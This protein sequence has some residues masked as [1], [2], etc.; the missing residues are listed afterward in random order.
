[1]FCW[2]AHAMVWGCQTTISGAELLLLCSYIYRSIFP[3][4]YKFNDIF[5][6]QFLYRSFFFF[7]QDVEDKMLFMQFKMHDLM[8]DL[9]LSSAR[10]ECS[11]ISS[12]NLQ[13]SK[14]TWHLTFLDP[15]FFFPSSSYTPRD[16]IVQEHFSFK[17]F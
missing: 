2:I 4:D 7:F 11:I 13:I 17:I 6:V 16:W 14:T 15:H 8:H 5:W 12:N 3:K 1:M 10:I 9:A